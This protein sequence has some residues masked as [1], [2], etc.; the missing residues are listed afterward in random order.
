MSRVLTLK[1]SYYKAL[2]RLTVEL[3]GINLGTDHEFLIETRLSTLARKEGFS[4]LNDMIEEL[5]FRG[6]ARL[7]IKIVSSLLERD[8]H[9]YTDLTSYEQLEDIVLP[10]LYR[11]YKGSQIRILSFGC[12]SGQEPYGIAMRLDKIRDRFEGMEMSIHGVD[13]PSAALERARTG[14]YSHFD[15]QRGLPI[16]ELITYFDRVGEDWRIKES[17]RKTVTFREFHLLSNL[18][19]LGDYHVVLFRNNLSF[20][21]T[22]AQVRVLRGLSKIVKPLGFLILGS[23]ESLK[24]INY[25]FD[26]VPGM[27]GVF[28]RREEKPEPVPEDPTIK[29]PSGRKTFEKTKRRT[30]DLLGAQ[31]AK[32]QKKAG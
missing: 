22:P 31:A 16:R 8:T 19:E 9:F 30:R 28:K 3:A 24:G 12:S 29:K 13:Y 14:R 2:K 7:A 5:F 6:Q 23:Q 20:Y 21:S 4:S 11:A 15:V 1:P 10:E 27:S 26:A 25:G 32:K 18:D 17:L